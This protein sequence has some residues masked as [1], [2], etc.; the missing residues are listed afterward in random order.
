MAAIR[1][2]QVLF[3]EFGFRRLA[4]RLS[5]VFGTLR[6]PAEARTR[7]VPDTI[8]PV[9]S[10]I[11]T[12]KA[13]AALVSE[14]RRQKQISIDTETTHIWPRWAEIVGIS[15]SWNE[16]QAYYLPLRGPQGSRLLD[17][18]CRS[19][20]CDRCWKTRRSASSART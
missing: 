12:P 8:K 7:S 1:P 15:L 19:T 17:P 11:D 5:Y 10:T 13:L 3:E 20:P 16:H 6:V 18:Q 9:Y 4:E 2:G 14:M